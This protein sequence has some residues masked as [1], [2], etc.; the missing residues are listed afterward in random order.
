MVICHI[1]FC[2]I[3][4][5]FVSNPSPSE[6]SQSSLGTDLYIINTEDEMHIDTTN[7]T[8]AKRKK[9]QH[10]TEF[11]EEY[12][13]I[14]GE[15]AS[16]HT[17]MKRRIS[18]MNSPMPD[19]VCKEEMQNATVDTNDIIIEYITD[20]QGKKIK[21]LK[22]LLIKTEPDREYIQHIHSDD[23]LPDVPENNFL[24]KR[25]VT[26]DSYSKTISS[27][28]SSDD[29]TITADS[30]G[31]TSSM[32][33]KSCVWEMDSTGIEAMLHQIAS[34]L[35]NAAEA[36]LTLASHIS[37]ITPYELSQVMAKVP[38][39]PIDVPMPIRKALSVDG[40]SKVV[41]YLLHG[42]YEMTNTSWSK[43]QKKYNLSKNKIYSALKGKRRP[44]GSQ[45]QQK[46]KQTT[47][48]KSTTSHTNSGTE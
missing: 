27:D 1:I 9:L 26:I 5:A 23:N 21:K 44:R 2:P 32:E 29:S 7:W 31:S 10:M 45:Y 13:W 19:S 33:D 20:A 22:P 6:D 39:P 11:H 48:P 46:K 40:E 36:Y 15:K 3:A 14:I 28:S 37:K 8:L 43:L 12:Q 16:I 41:N 25:E 47:K 38:P 17:I 34:G 35:Q 42:E 30:D 24:Q 18:H 4:M